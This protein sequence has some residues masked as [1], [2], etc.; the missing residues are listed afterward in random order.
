MTALIEQETDALT[1]FTTAWCGHCARLKSQLRRAGIPYAEVDIEFDRSAAA[2]VAAANRGNLTVPTVQF[3]DGSTMT[4][5]SLSQVGSKLG[6][7][8]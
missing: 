1:V 3:D 7:Q 8:A 5:P 2:V 4:N 6:F